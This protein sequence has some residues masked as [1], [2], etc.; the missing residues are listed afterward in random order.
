MLKQVLIGDG[1]NAEENMIDI[2]FNGVACLA[3]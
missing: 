1:V 2:D 3:E